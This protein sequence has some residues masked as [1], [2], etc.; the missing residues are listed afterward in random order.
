MGALKIVFVI[1]FYFLFYFFVWLRPRNPPGLIK[2][3]KSL[4]L[5]WLSYTSYHTHR[6]PKLKQVHQLAGLVSR[7]LGWL[8]FQAQPPTY[9]LKMA[10]SEKVGLTMTRPILS[11][12]TRLPG[13]LYTY[14]QQWRQQ[15]QQPWLSAGAARVV[16]HLR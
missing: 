9:L 14:D 10:L 4:S 3:V 8:G 6:A 5:S 1:L 12:S 7:Q 2:A 16:T 11:M 13:C 15:Q